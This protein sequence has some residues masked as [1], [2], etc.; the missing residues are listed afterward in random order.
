MASSES[1]N[2]AK[3]RKII[4]IMAIVAAA[5]AVIA[6]IFFNS[7]MSSESSHNISRFF[8]R[9]ILPFVDTGAEW[10]DRSVADTIVRKI[11][12]AVIYCALAVILTC[13]TLMLRGRARGIGYVI[14]SVG[15][16][17]VAS[18]DE[19]IQHYSG[20]GASVTDVAIDMSGAAAG[21][22][23]VS[24]IYLLIQKIKKMRK[25]NKIR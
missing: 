13:F 2:T 10:T 25:N 14:S 3:R 17:C 19:F 6:V 24:L 5:L 12:H 21:M 23:T 1:K 4:L 9:L 20:R 8:S 18:A 7:V 22:L 16:L 15:I 11:A